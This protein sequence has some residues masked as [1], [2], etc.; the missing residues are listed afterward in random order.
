MSFGSED[1]KSVTLMV[2][3]DPTGSEEFYLLKAPSALTIVSAYAVVEQTQNDGT[4]FLMTLTNWGTAGTAVQSGGTIA[5]ALGGTAALA[6]LT[7]KTPAAAT[8]SSTE[9]YVDANEWLVLQYTE[10]G[11]GWISGDFFS[12]TVN[13][14]LGKG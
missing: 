14:R 3:S 6:V 2:N 8:I 7:A 10:E 12:Y 9:K 5:S 1:I 13:Y 4:A 11:A